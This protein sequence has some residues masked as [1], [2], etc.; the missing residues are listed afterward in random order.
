MECARRVESITMVIWVESK[1]VQFQ[2]M[3][4][5]P[6]LCA[7]RSDSPTGSRSDQTNCRQ[8]RIHTIVGWDGLDGTPTQQDRALRESSEVVMPELIYDSRE[9]RQ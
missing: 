7:Q 8:A 3:Y 5:W 1:P 9:K 2:S 4:E 6:G